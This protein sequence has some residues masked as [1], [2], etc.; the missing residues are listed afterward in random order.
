M[1]KFTE[2]IKKFNIGDEYSFKTK[3]DEIDVQIKITYEESS[4]KGNSTFYRVIVSSYYINNMETY[5]DHELEYKVLN[6]AKNLYE[7]LEELKNKKWCKSNGFFRS[8]ELVNKI[9]GFHEVMGELFE[10]NKCS[11]CVDHCDELLNC[12]HILCMKC[13]SHM[14]KKQ[15]KECPICRSSCLHQYGESDDEE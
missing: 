10:I 12:G 5:K 2:I 3:I 7:Y 6:N 15:N 1:E 14:L 13:R 8:L 4:S 11:V 9:K